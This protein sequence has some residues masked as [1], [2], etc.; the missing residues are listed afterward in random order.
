MTFSRVPGFPNQITQRLSESGVAIVVTL[1]P[2]ATLYLYLK[3]V[4][5]H[6]TLYAKRLRSAEFSLVQAV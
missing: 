1:P 6:L 4:Q 2:G 3:Q 5:S